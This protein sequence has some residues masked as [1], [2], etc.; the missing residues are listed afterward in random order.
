M[1]FLIQKDSQELTDRK[2]ADHNPA[3]MPYLVDRG[4]SKGPVL[5]ISLLFATVGAA[6]KS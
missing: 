3:R 4:R 5:C 6:A 2:V 1:E